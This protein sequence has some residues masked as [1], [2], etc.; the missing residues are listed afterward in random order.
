MPAV[1]LGRPPRFSDR[2][3][4][5]QL[6]LSDNQTLERIRNNKEKQAQLR[7][8]AKREGIEKFNVDR[9]G[10]VDMLTP[11]RVMDDKTR[12]GNSYKTSEFLG[13][14]HQEGMDY[15]NQAKTPYNPL[16]AAGTTVA[17]QNA[18]ESMPRALVL[19]GQELMRNKPDINS[20]EWEEWKQ[21]N[22][23]YRNKVFGAVEDKN[24]QDMPDTYKN[25]DG[26]L[27]KDKLTDD[28]IADNVNIDNKGAV[29]VLGDNDTG[30]NPPPPLPSRGS[31]SDRM[32]ESLKEGNN[33]KYN[34]SAN[35]NE[36]DVDY[37]PYKREVTNV[38]QGFFDPIKE[39]ERS[40]YKQSAITS[41]MNGFKAGTPEEINR[42]AAMLERKQQINDDYN[43][44]IANDS[45]S[46]TV[47]GG[48]KYKGGSSNWSLG[49]QSGT[50]NSYK[51]NIR[52]N[53]NFGGGGNKFKK[54]VGYFNYGDVNVAVIGNND[55]TISTDS[56][57]QHG[58]L[59]Q[60]HPRINDIS[61]KAIQD[62]NYQLVNP[63]E[64]QSLD[65]PIPF[66]PKNGIG[67][68]RINMNGA[69]G[70]LVYMDGFKLKGT[71]TDQKTKM[72]HTFFT[73]SGGSFASEG[74]FDGNVERLRQMQEE[75]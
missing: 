2:L 55:G 20:P 48:V 58:T 68:A 22:D 25:K 52:S 74:T 29:S 1:I 70:L 41:I 4:E 7:N 63:N 18:F 65:N 53:S 46:D 57:V 54:P 73:E 14:P 49:E 24:G 28:Y 13:D 31:I 11:E 32:T 51:F 50:D 66:D 10:V 44:A 17:N 60:R 34:V 39:S 3:Q 42:D 16:E 23:K 37:D 12:E 71:A 61:R 27:N 62:N 9:H 75:K 6:L 30:G 64:I 21:E 36:G 72:S 59:A 56:V 19:E 43:K 45:Y 40:L 35:I 67:W 5:H 26:T 8:L 69:K 15:I 33:Y 38:E 47:S